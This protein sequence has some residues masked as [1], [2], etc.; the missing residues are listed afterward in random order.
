MEA[1]TQ[2]DT[3]SVYTAPGCTGYTPEAEAVVT[4]SCSS[5]ATDYELATRLWAKRA[6]KLNRKVEKLRKKNKKLTK[7]ILK[8]TRDLLERKK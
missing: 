5:C 7:M 4:S 3:V 1:S 6:R 8:T 2:V